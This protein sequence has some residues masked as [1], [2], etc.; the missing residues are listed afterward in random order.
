MIIIQPRLIK[1]IDWAH[2]WFNLADFLCAIELLKCYQI[3]NR[4]Q[5]IPDLICNFCHEILVAYAVNSLSAAQEYMGKCT[6]SLVYA[7]HL[8]IKCIYHLQNACGRLKI[9]LGY[10]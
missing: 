7:K 9:Y 4:T 6:S 8:L 5:Q 2:A 10:A 1:P 3:W